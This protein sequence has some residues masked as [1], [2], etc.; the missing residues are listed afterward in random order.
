MW[1][2]FIIWNDWEPWIQLL[3]ICLCWD[4][5]NNMDS[6]NADSHMHMHALN[7]LCRLC[8]KPAVQNTKKT[9]NRPPKEVTK[10]TLQ[11]FS[12]FGIHVSNVEPTIHPNHI[13]QSCCQTMVN[14]AKRGEPSHF[15]DTTVKVQ[16]RNSLWSWHNDLT[17]KTCNIYIS[18]CH[19]GRDDIQQLDIIMNDHLTECNPY[20]QQ[21]QVPVKKRKTSH[22]H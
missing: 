20:I 11:I 1:I 2:R 4:Q 16:N 3:L 15:H 17:C 18:Q 19:G 14:V 6:N 9:Y 7:R 12:V 22:K 10:N 13:C 5:Q 8:A 21:E